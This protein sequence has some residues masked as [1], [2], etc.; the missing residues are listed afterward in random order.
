ME[1]YRE[2]EIIVIPNDESQYPY[3]AIARIGDTE[4]KHKGQSKS[5]AIDLVKQS[6]N[7]LESKHIL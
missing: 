2:H 6:I 7:K 4:I 1:K 3:K 5:A